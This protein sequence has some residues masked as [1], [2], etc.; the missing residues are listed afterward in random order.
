MMVLLNYIMNHLENKLHISTLIFRWCQTR[1]IELNGVQTRWKLVVAVAKKKS[2]FSEIVASFLGFK[3]Y[4]NT[5][6]YV[7]ISE[8]C[9]KDRLQSFMLFNV[10]TLASLH[11]KLVISKY[12]Q[13]YFAAMLVISRFWSIVRNKKSYPLL[14]SNAHELDSIN[15]PFVFLKR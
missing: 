14:K 2:D 4:Y 5:A 6:T 3:L 7:N 13:E 8:K 11:V 15:H 1:C 12:E 10:Y 9:K